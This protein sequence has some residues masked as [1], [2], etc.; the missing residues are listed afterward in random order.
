MNMRETLRGAAG[1]DLTAR[2]KS[3]A[4]ELGA[5][6]VNT[7]AVERWVSA[8]YD[9]TKAHVYPHTG[10]LPTEILPSARSVIMIAV[11]QLDGV[12]DTS[13]TACK[14]T[15]VQGNFGYVY[16]NRKLSD[17]TFK[18]AQ[19]LEDEFDYRSVP[20]GYNIGSR[21]DHRADVDTTIIGPAY[22]LF[23]MKRAA[24]LAGLGRKARNGV[25]ASPEFG[26]RMRLGGVITAAPVT[27]DPVLE[28]DPCPV[29]CNI[30]MKVCPTDAISP[31]GKVDHLR[32]FADAGSQGKTYKDIQTQFKKRY[33]PD[34]EGV[35]YR[36]ND[37]LAMDGRSLRLCKV[38]CV[39]FCPLGERR[40]PDVVRRVKD[41]ASILPKV[42]LQD[43]PSGR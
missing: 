36:E 23:N 11:R 35:D 8:D 16:L 21:Y 14:T 38:S 19:W 18:I 20:L 40:M 4:L 17:V 1:T 2:I 30:C 32:C 37:Y 33:P 34:V 26:T 9:E 27:S 6:L 43:F 25:V 29:G 42:E 12:M 13:V 15:A 5:D 7:A 3:K 10:Y 22:G 24:V 31:D 28:G 41:F 39:A